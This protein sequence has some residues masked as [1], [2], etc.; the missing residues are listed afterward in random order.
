MRRILLNGKLSESETRR[1]ETSEGYLVQIDVTM[2]VLRDLKKILGENS[3]KWFFFMMVMGSLSALSYLLLSFSNFLP[4][5][6]GGGIPE[7]DI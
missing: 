5:L 7:P 2:A 3:P 6:G 1:C 4:C